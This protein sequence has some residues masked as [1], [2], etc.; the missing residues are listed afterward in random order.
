M[1]VFLLKYLATWLADNNKNIVDLIVSAIRSADAKFASG[2]DKFKYVREK[3]ASYLTGKAG[4]IVDTVIH[5]LLAW[6]RK[7]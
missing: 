2:P 5:L 4:W 1:K 6:T 7:S 3:A